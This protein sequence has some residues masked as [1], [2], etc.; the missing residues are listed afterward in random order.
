MRNKLYLLLLLFIACAT[1]FAK[2]VYM[3]PNGSDGADGTIGHP[4]AT[5]PA[6]YK[7]IEGGDTI[8]VRDGVYRVTDSQVMK[9]DKGYAYVFALEKAGTAKRRTCI[10]GYPGERPVFDFSALM[11]D[12]K[13]RFGAFYLGAD[14]LHLKNF[15][16]VGVPVRMKGHTQSECVSAKKG[17]HCIVEN[18][19]MHDGMA[20]GYYQTAG[21]DNLI[22]NCDA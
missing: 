18:L 13:W 5:L 16:I 22:L 11:L 6:A 4:F 8:C 1:G 10:M 3:S 21:A 2:V 17:S 7:A 12:G 9:K 15:D 14:Y 19:A 20:I